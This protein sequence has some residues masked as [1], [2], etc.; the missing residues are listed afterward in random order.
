M[1]GVND[2]L[3]KASNDLMASKKLSDAN[4]TF[5][6][7]VFH[8]HQ[9]AE[10]SLKAFIVAAQQSVPRTHDLG[11]LF[12]DC[13]KIDPNL[14]LLSNESKALNPYGY[15]SRYPNDSFYVN[16]QKVDDAIAMAERIFTVI[17]TVLRSES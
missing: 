9:C 2:W 3:R 13:L 8:T 17:K 1:P 15:D 14:M 16:K 10:K 12:F 4:E 7:S 6:C 5:D 11:F